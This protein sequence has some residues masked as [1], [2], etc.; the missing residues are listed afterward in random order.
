MYIQIKDNQIIAKAE[1]QFPDSVYTDREVV[2]AWDGK[3]YFSGEEPDFIDY[4]SYDCKRADEYP[5]YQD[6]LDA[7]VKINSEDEALIASG[8]E[9]L[10]TYYAT[11][12]AIKNK[13]PKE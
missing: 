10:K 1:W 3:F 2:T 8:E 12:L 9:Q 11:C 4:R 7:M 13:Y 6:Y 5:P